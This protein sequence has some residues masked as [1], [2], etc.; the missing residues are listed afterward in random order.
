MN[1]QRYNT[2]SKR[3][4]GGIFVLYADHVAALAEAE[5]RVRDEERS[6]FQEAVWTFD[7]GHTQGRAEALRQTREAVAVAIGRA[8]FL[9]IMDAGIAEKV[10]CEAIDALK[11]EQA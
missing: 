8:R 2:M 7:R 1:V 3:S 9:N 5:Q 10:A 11:G 6:H 4:A